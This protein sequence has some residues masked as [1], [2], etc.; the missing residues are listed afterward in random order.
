MPL[1]EFRVLDRQFHTLIANACGN[2]LLARSTAR[3]STR[4]SAAASSRRC[5][6]PR[7]TATEVDE[8]IARSIDEHQAIAKA[9]VDGTPRRRVG[10]VRVPPPRRRAAHGRGPDLALD[11]GARRTDMPDL[12]HAYCYFFDDDAFHETDRPGFRRRVDHRRA[13][14]AVLLAHHRRRR[15]ASF[16]HHHA[17]NE[18]LGIIMRGALDFR[19]GDPT[20]SARTVLNDG[21]RLPRPGR[22]VARRPRVHRRRRVRRV[23]DPRRVR[24]AAHR[25]ARGRL[26]SAPTGAWPSTSAA[27]SP[28]SCCSTRRRGTVVVDKT[29]TTPSAPLD[30]VRAGVASCSPRP[31]CARPTSRRRSCTPRR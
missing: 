22:R 27:R 24:P 19:I 21:R 16:L 10:A 29:L 26:M 7:P 5:C 8:L 12:Q 14:A 15:P 3:C 30:G 28:T 18:Q 6:T 20:T 31:A 25:P 4:C 13:P 23:L 2:P 17:D 11:R 1:D 9:I